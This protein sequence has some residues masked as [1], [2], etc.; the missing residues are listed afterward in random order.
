MVR[1][2]AI[3]FRADEPHWARRDLQEREALHHWQSPGVSAAAHIAG[4][5]QL[6]QSVIPGHGDLAGWQL[7]LMLGR[8]L[9][10]HQRQSRFGLGPALSQKACDVVAP[11]FGFQH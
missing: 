4:N 3:G 10:S 6:L 9:L 7:E 8:W 2:L 11:Q 1:W 5:V